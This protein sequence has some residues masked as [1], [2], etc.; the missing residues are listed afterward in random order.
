MNQ[1]QTPKIKKTNEN[2]E[3]VSLDNKGEFELKDEMNN[4]RK[5]RRRSSAI[6]E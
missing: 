2:N 6:I 5:K 3:I 1:M 4:S